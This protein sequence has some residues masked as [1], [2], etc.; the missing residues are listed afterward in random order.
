MQ[1][2]YHYCI[3]ISVK[4]PDNEATSFIPEPEVIENVPVNLLLA[5]AVIV[6]VPAL[7]FHIPVVPGYK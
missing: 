7:P 3:G 4:L 6:T 1:T 5:L 2:F